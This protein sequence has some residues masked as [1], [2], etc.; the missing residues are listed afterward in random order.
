MVRGTMELQKASLACL[1]LVLAV[2]PALKVSTQQPQGPTYGA[3]VVRG[4]IYADWTLAMA[5]SMKE[6]VPV[7][8]L[9][10]EVNEEEVIGVLTSLSEARRSVLIVGDSMAVPRGFEIIL[11]SMRIDVDRVGGATRADT[12]LQMIIRGFWADSRELVVVNG[13]KRELYIPA[14]SLSSTYLAPIIYSTE[15]RLPENFFKVL[16]N[17]M[18]NLETVYV[19]DD[20]LIE[21]EV[22]E[23][24]NKGYVIKELNITTVEAPKKSSLQQALLWLRERALGMIVGLFTGTILSYLIISGRKRSPTDLLMSFLTRDERTLVEIIR[25]NKEVKQ[26]DLPELTGFSRPKVSRMVNEL[27]SRGILEKEVF[28]KTYV[29]RIRNLFKEE[30]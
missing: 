28:G 24:I 19:L 16:E 9:Y 22:A 4:D 25:R 1:V 12:S 11:K 29:L 2:L 15:G 8:T 6:R 20:S 18:P 30:T 14:L 27:V 17:Y 23:L 5:F 13:Q 21:E 7:L 26:E 10:K 3:I